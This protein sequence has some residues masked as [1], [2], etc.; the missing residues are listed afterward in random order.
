MSQRADD[1]QGPQRTPAD[2]SKPNANLYTLGCVLAPDPC[3]LVA[4]R[5]LRE[6]RPQLGGLALTIEGLKQRDLMVFRV[7]KTRG[8][9]V[10]VFL[11]EPIVPEPGE[12]AGVGG[13]IIGKAIYEG[14]I[15]F[16]DLKRFLC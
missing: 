7:A 14:T 13:A 5:G 11:G 16:A 12:K 6:L 8:V 9:P 10:M 4:R 1:Y 3:V 2:P 15:T